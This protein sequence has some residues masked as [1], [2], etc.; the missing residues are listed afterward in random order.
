MARDRAA[1][2]TGQS[3][4]DIDEHRERFRR[5]RS[6]AT[7]H[8]VLTV[9]VVALL[10]RAVVAVAV[11]SLFGGAL[12]AYDSHAYSTMAEAYAAGNTHTWD[13]F[14]HRLFWDTA[15][16]LLPIAFIYKL[17]G[18]VLLAGQLYVA[19]LGAAAAALTSWLAYQLLGARWALAGGLALAFLPSQIYWSTQVLKDPAVWAVSAALAVIVAATRQ[20]EPQQLIKF[21][22]MAA[23]VLAVMG[24]L[25][26]HTL[27]VISWA[28][29][30][31]TWI[32]SKHLRLHR[33]AGGILLGITIPW[34]FGLGPAGWSL[35][36]APANLAERRYLNAQGA[37]TAIVPTN[38]GTAEE[39]AVRGEA[40]Q[41]LEQLKQATKENEVELKARVEELR[42][43]LDPAD[44]AEDGDG[45]SP[46]E[47][48]QVE[49]ILSLQ[50]ERLRAVRAE[51]RQILNTLAP[52]TVEQVEAAQEPN[53]MHLPKGIFVM[54]FEPTPMRG[55][56][57]PTIGLARTE[58]LLWY[59]L[60]LLAVVGLVPALKRLHV[61]LFPLL[62]GGA[63]LLVYALTEGNVGTAYRHR[64]EFVWVVAL[65]ATIG[66]WTLY[67]KL[68]ARIVREELPRNG[69]LIS[70]PPKTAQI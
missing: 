29:M 41:Q 44:R 59:P 64:G 30:L 8:P 5:L 54:L 36:T 62:S 50:E 1:K 49:R 18:P 40:E 70:D 19:L 48:R 33:I 2:P 61:M 55:G 4:R 23:V 27:V 6:L 66:L 10:V 17:I 35:I 51:I 15:T 42:D 25:R 7:Q 28:L 57:D 11:N 12:L 65:L 21:G 26:L 69:T 43:Q 20:A 24:F 45:L 39:E 68:R 56:D 9:F 60:L 31:S 52:P 3:A 46:A 22:V 34:L 47:R 63:L 32:G 38:V 37:E 16:L 58:T 53:L 67:N 13:A 14:T